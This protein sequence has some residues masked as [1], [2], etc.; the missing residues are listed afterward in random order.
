MGKAPSGAR[1]DLGLAS[2][3]ACDRASRRGNRSGRF[4]PSGS[5]SASAISA[6]NCSLYLLGTAARQ[7]LSREAFVDERRE[8]QLLDDVQKRAKWSFGGDSSTD[9]GRRCGVSRPY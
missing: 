1:L 3:T 2:P 8:I 4:N 9:G 7:A 5:G 6:C